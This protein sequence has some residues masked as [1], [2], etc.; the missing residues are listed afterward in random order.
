VAVGIKLDD[1]M[2]DWF[3]AQGRGCQTRI[4]SVL[5]RYVEAQRKAG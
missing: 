5:R 4:N 1:D 3:K 2:L